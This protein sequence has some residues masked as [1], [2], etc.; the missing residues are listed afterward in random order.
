MT[1]TATPMCAHRVF[2]AQA[3]R[4]PERI[5]ISDGDVDATYRELDTRANHL[6][7]RLIALGV[8]AQDRVA[9]SLPRSTT[10]GIISRVSI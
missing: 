2:E 5:A 8:G 1:E 4:H 10:S 3:A 9:I 7:H 6:T